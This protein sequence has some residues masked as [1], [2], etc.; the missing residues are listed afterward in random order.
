MPNINIKLTEE[1]LEYIRSFKREGE[2]WREFIQRGLW[3]KAIQNRTP[4]TFIPKEAWKTDE[5]I[6]IT[7]PCHPSG[8]CAY[9]SLVEE[10]PFQ[11][12]RDE[13]SCRT[14]GHTCPMF[15]MAS[16]MAETPADFKKRKPKPEVEEPIPVNE[17]IVTPEPAPPVQPAGL[18]GIR[19]FDGIMSAIKEGEKQK[20]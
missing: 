16:A 15:Y 17:P 13:M 1:E 11:T 20:R 3:L 12:P 19:G 9:G 6:P 5:D 18:V 4:A 2:S 10:F 7:K 14:Y 8:M